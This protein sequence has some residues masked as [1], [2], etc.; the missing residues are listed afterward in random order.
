MAQ[1]GKVDTCLVILLALKTLPL[2]SSGERE[3]FR[4]TSHYGRPSRE[5]VGLSGQM[6]LR[7]QISGLQIANRI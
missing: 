5:V 3:A 4:A 1:V 2:G 7:D 6:L